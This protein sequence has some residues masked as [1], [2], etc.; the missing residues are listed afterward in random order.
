MSL[1]SPFGLP[2]RVDHPSIDPT[3]WEDDEDDD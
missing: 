3:K 2:L 1:D